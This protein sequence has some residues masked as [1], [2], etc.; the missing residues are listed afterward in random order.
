MAVLFDKQADLYL[1]GRPTYPTQWYS[2]LADHTLHHSLAWDVGTGNGQAALGVAEHYEQVIGTDV[3]EAQLKHAMAHPR[4]RYLPTQLSMSDDE[5]ITLI[6]G[7]NSVDLVTVAQ[8]VHWFDLPKFY[9]LVA[10]LLRKPGGVLAVWCYNDILVSPAFEP[11]FKQ[12]HDSTLPFW[13]PNIQHI[14]DGYKKLPFPFENIGLG[15]EGKPLE[16]D[17]S[18][19]LSFEGFLKM[20]SSWSAVITAKNQ[21]V[22]LLSPTVVKELETVWGGPKLVRSVTYKAFMLAGKA[23]L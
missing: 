8:A 7:E 1:D 2:M 5:L 15:S 12:F 19:E 13:H 23:K 22:D 6:G 20:I 21:G 11:V 4:V 3:S 18:K 16:L 10:R 9:S 14:F 17:I